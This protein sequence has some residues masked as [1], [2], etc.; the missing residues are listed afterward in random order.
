MNLYYKV[1][2]C[3]DTKSW[4]KPVLRQIE[5]SIS[6][7]TALLPALKVIQNPTEIEISEYNNYDL[8]LF[9]YDFSKLKS[10]D[11]KV[12]N[13]ARLIELVRSSQIYTPVIFYS[14]QPNFMDVIKNESLEGV[15]FSRRDN[16][17]TLFLDI[18]KVAAIT[19]RR[20]L[21]PSSI[22]G[23]FLSS[24]AEI[25]SDLVD[26]LVRTNDIAIQAFNL[27]GS[28]D[29]K[30][31]KYKADTI[32]HLKSKSLE[33]DS[34][35]LN[36][37]GSLTDFKSMVK[38][39]AFLD[40]AKKADLAQSVFKLK[41]IGEIIN[42]IIENHQMNTVGGYGNLFKNEI[43]DLRNDLA[44][45][46]LEDIGKHIQKRIDMF[47][48]YNDDRSTIIEGIDESSSDAFKYLMFIVKL[49]SRHKNFICDALEAFP[50]GAKEMSE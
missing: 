46:K 40:L 36:W 27:S 14:S 9:D 4:Q 8:L 43:S 1:L 24:V 33:Q 30:F 26:L 31:K 19:V 38:E 15:Y 3:D 29:K 28:F 20:M 21:D 41:A 23:L 42:P 37:N 47:R 17:G 18:E 16:N 7:A 49:L 39:R 13:G 48:D 11:K 2:L 5:D 44:H 50:V 35:I 32:E 10:Q 6:T 45:E 34:R 25:E 22:R 12:E